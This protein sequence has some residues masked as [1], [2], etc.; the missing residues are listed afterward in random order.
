VIATAR[1]SERRGSANILELEPAFCAGLSPDAA[2]AARE[3]ASVATFV[4]EPGAWDGRADLGDRPG[5]LGLLVVEGFLGRRVRVGPQACTELLGSGDLIRPWDVPDDLASV[6][7]VTSWT[8]FTAITVA[9][10]DE[11]FVG[12][13]C[14]WPPVIAALAK[15]MMERSR[16]LAFH[17]AVCHL[18]RVE[19][20]LLVVLWHFADRWG[21]VTPDG[22]ALGLPLTHELLAHI[23]GARRPTVT[24]ALQELAARGLV[25]RGEGRRLLLHGD[26]PGELRELRAQVAG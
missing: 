4:V 7:A 2:R 16:T 8:V 25:T 24:T 12:R 23:V 20:R 10:I 9:L 11:R 21:R 3:A 22:V 1:S 19:Q 26:P 5:D 14:A 18:T 17:L 6:P 15:R 13:M